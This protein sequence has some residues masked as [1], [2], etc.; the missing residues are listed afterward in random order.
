MFIFM[1]Y[2]LHAS[3]WSFAF[4][5]GTGKPSCSWLRDGAW[6]V[7]LFRLSV[8]FFTEPATR[9]T[10]CCMCIK[11]LVLGL[12]KVSII[13][14]HLLIG[15]LHVQTTYSNLKSIWQINSW[16]EGLSLISRYFSDFIILCNFPPP[17]L[18]EQIFNAPWHYYFLTL[19]RRASV[20]L[21]SE[22]NL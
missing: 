21:D 13:N 12:S 16:R 4:Y 2:P 19:I 6:F 17:N 3:S 1:S 8:Q 20:C 14:L 22:D 11:F 10:L 18:N 9:D 7:L 5:V 15:R